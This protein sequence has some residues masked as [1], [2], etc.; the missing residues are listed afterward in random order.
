M[1]LLKFVVAIL[2]AA[3][4]TLVLA[5]SNP[6]LS[7]G[8][9]PTAAQWNNYFSSKLD[10]VAGF[11]PLN[12]SGG[13]MTG[14]LTTAPSTAARAGFN[15]PVGVVPT[16]PVDGNVWCTSAGMFGRFG[17][18][19]A[20]PFGTGGGGGSVTIGGTTAS[21]FGLT[22]LTMTG[23]NITAGTMA[24]Q[25]ASAVA[26]TGGSMAGVNINMASGKTLINLTDPTSAQDAATKHYVDTAITGA[27]TGFNPVAT[28][29]VATAAILPNS[30]TYSNGTLGVGATLTST[31]N[32]AL[33]VDGTILAVNDIV[34]VKTQG[35][36]FQNGLYQVTQ[37]GSVSTTWILTRIATFDQAAE[38]KA[39]SSS[40]VSGG[41]TQAGTWVL[42]PAVTTVG[43]DP[44]NWTVFS[45]AGVT[46]IAGTTGPFTCATADINCGTS[47]TIQFATQL[48][49]TVMGNFTGS[50]AKPLAVAMPSCADTAGN[51]LNYVSGTGIT[52][53][54]S[55]IAGGC[56]VSSV[57]INTTM[58]STSAC[59]TV[60]VDASG[61]ARTITLFASAGGVSGYTVNVKKIDSSTNNVIVVVTGGANIDGTTS[62]VIGSQWS[63]KNLLT[64]SSQWLT[65]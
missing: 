50:T 63:N 19:T 23:G 1:R 35:S 41:A 3:L 20:G 24:S 44:L 17:G 48:A 58:S 22:N 9:V 32:A 40:A 53:G 54:T 36:A 38:M 52:C 65:L 13:T 33:V 45:L 29:R 8:Q 26:I 31:A 42:N 39:N 28:S 51:H 10:Y 25:A 49:N 60:L 55:S 5:Q 2:F 18:V 6:G 57:A 37:A 56:S 47:S 11:V 21:T 46:S 59:Q 7:R 61:G 12:T 64:T 15:C 4:P 27:A 16:T 34:L 14:A 62:I 43:T 30:P